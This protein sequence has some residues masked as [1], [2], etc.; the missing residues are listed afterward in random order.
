MEFTTTVAG[1]PCICKVT[2]Y[3]KE[4]Q[5]SQDKYGE[6][7]PPEHAIFEFEILDRKGYPAGWLEKK[8][9]S[10]A[11]DQLYSQYLALVENEECYS[12]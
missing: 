2:D 9:T 12:E 11:R 6:A 7:S 4:K 5:W 8:L 10:T 3:Q 1:I